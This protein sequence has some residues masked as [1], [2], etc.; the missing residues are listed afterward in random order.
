MI[1][2]FGALAAYG[3]TL[4]APAPKPRTA[5]PAMPTT[6]TT[7]IP[8]AETT[9]TTT[10]ESATPPVV[11][12]TQQSST[13][14]QTTSAPTPAPE[15][16]PKPKPK[17]KWH[18][19]VGYSRADASDLA[20]AWLAGPVYSGGLKHPDRLSKLCME[21]THQGVGDTLE[22]ECVREFL[23]KSGMYVSPSF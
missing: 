10:A 13:T 12:T 22:H 23:V 16:K 5:K 19:T 3:S 9:P 4:P 8:A 1:A 14:T 2:V 11:T 17:P 7:P 6:T 18:W 20:D 21:L 15:P